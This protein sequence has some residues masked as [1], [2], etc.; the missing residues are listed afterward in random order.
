MLSVVK[1]ENL[2]VNLILIMNL[3]V[4][5]IVGLP[6]SGSSAAGRK[7]GQGKSKI[8]FF[9]PNNAGYTLLVYTYI[10]YDMIKQKKS[11]LPRIIT[12]LYITYIIIHSKNICRMNLS[13]KD[14]FHQK[15]FIE[16]I[17][18]SICVHLANIMELQKIFLVFV[19]ACIMSASAHFCKYI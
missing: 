17:Q 16:R 14:E 5:L 6:A 11:A 10:I 3:I 2:I 18:N 7:K 8:F 15:K 4:N 1:N 9:Y 12:I 19:L 13:L